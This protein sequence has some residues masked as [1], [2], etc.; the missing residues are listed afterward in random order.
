MRISALKIAYK[1]TQKW[2]WQQKSDYLRVKEWNM[3][4]ESL[5]SS[6]AVLAKEL[7]VLFG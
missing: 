2:N 6:A 1:L 3:G 4:N 5:I 7:L